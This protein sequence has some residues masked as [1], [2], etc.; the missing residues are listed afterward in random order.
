MRLWAAQPALP[1]KIVHNI[2]WTAERLKFGTRP[3][4]AWL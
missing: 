2:C 4:A 1:R 3:A